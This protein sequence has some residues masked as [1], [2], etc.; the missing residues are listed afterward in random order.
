MPPRQRY[1][2]ISNNVQFQKSFLQVRVVQTGILDFQ[3]Y[4]RSLQLYSS[5]PT[6]PPNQLQQIRFIFQK[7][8]KTKTKMSRDTK[9]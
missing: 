4:F 5:A 9:K 1:Q 6:T 3:F 8:D 7:D 2:V